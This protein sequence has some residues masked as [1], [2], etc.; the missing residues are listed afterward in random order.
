MNTLLYCIVNVIQNPNIFTSV[1]Y[2]ISKKRLILIVMTLLLTEKTS[3]WL[4]D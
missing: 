1:V 3:F 4:M 2:T